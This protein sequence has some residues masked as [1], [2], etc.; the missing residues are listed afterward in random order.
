MAIS[1]STA[2]RKSV[3]AVSSGSRAI[4]VSSYR[5]TTSNS[6]SHHKAVQ[7]RMGQ[8]WISKKQDDWNWKPMAAMLTGFLAWSGGEQAA[9]AAMCPQLTKSESG[10]E[11]CDVKEGDGDTPVKG[12]FIKV[13]YSGRLDSDSASGTFDSSYDRGRPL[14]FAVGTGQVIKGWD[15][16]ILGD[17]KT[18]PGMKPGGK[19]QLVIPP[20]LGYGERG[21]GGGIIPPNATLYFD[22]EYLGRLGQK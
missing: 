2:T 9:Y 22:V 5:Y 10:L 4:R 11:F 3:V 19:R 8:E 1:A 18:V 17:G 21:A 16:G 7:G 13:H 14:G 15:Q 20:G 12:A 6:N